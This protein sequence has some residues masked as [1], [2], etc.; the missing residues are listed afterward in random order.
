MSAQLSTT[1]VP[2][3]LHSVM[4]RLARPVACLPVMSEGSTPAGQVSV[5]EQERKLDAF[6]QWL[7]A[8]STDDEAGEGEDD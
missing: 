5:E 3:V 4:A 2:T 6:G 7:E 8:G 1:P